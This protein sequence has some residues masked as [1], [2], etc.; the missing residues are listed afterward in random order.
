[1][2]TVTGD[3][4]SDAVIHGREAVPDDVVHNRSYDPAITAAVPGALSS[5]ANG[6]GDPRGIS[7]IWRLRHGRPDLPPGWMLTSRL[8]GGPRSSS[9]CGRR[10]QA[11]QRAVRRTAPLRMSSLTK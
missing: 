1:M 5:V 3:P 4:A 11:E 7:V 9:R 10:A 8:P 2:T 6:G